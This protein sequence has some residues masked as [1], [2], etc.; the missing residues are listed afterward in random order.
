MIKYQLKALA[1][2]M[3]GNR[4]VYGNYVDKHSSPDSIPF[5]AC[6][7]TKDLINDNFSIPLS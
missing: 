4:V 1:Q 7:Q 5:S 3:I 6:I 2:E